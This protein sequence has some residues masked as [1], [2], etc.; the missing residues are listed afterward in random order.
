MR[1]LFHL[2]YLNIQHSNGY[3]NNISK[4]SPPF[5]KLYQIFYKIATKISKTHFGFGTT[6]LRSVCRRSNL[7]IKKSPQDFTPEGILNYS[8]TILA[9]SIPLNTAGRSTPAPRKPS[10]SWV[11]LPI[12]LPASWPESL[13]II[14]MSAPA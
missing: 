5:I 14:W 1:F 8:L 4:Q 6:R 7:G 11:I 9:P 3:L 10:I 12:I 2:L 13:P